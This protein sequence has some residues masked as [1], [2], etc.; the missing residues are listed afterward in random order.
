MIPPDYIAW[1]AGTT[2]LDCRT[3]PPGWESIPG[4]LK[5]FTNKGS[6][7]PGSTVIPY[8]SSFQQETLTSERI[9]QRRILLCRICSFHFKGCLLLWRPFWDVMSQSTHLSPSAT[10]KHTYPPPP[11]PTLI[12]WYSRTAWLAS[13]LDNNL[14][15]W[16][17]CAWPNQEVWSSIFK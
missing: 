11:L 15:H 4:L 12:S 17:L 1:Q 14:S 5:W 7:P 16:C 3:G 2:K 8:N 10:H 13:F 9:G 6:G